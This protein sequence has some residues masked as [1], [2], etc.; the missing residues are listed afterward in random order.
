MIR[1]P[2]CKAENEAGPNCRRCRADL[3][4]LFA[5]EARREALL[6][7]ARARVAAGRWAEAYAAASEADALRRGEDSLRL[8]ALASLL[9]DDFHQALRAYLARASK[10]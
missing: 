5:L 2:V 8:V 7:S 6:A 10:Q 3:S 9:C 4:P 1:C